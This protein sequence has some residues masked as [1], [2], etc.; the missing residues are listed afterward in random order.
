MIKI[1]KLFDGCLFS[2]QA[3]DL[4]DP[5]VLSQAASEAGVTLF[6]ESTSALP[7]D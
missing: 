1:G 4:R 6:A 3:V 7:T 2:L 5:T